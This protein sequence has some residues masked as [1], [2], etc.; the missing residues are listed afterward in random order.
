MPLGNNTCRSTRARPTKPRVNQHQRPADLA[1]SA[2]LRRF[3][4]QSAG[5]SVWILLSGFSYTPCSVVWAMQFAAMT[6]RLRI[7]ITEEL[8]RLPDTLTPIPQSARPLNG[9]FQRAASGWRR[10][11][12]NA[13]KRSSKYSN[14]WSVWR[15][16][17]ELPFLFRGLPDAHHTPKYRKNGNVNPIAKAA[18]A[19]T[20]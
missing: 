17:S 4:S 9:C 5:F 12:P 13:L 19:W 7:D 18:A 11:W 8:A 3:S 16:F 20:M 10:R 15:S 1:Q 6:G 2:W 14:S